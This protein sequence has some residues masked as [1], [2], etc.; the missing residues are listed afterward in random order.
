[1][2]LKEEAQVAIVREWLAL[3]TSAR[4]TQYQAFLFAI[5]ARQ[6]FRFRC[7]GDPHQY[8]MGWLGPHIGSG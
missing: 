3:P 8:I 6:R 1:M 7:G 4:A 5:D 2:M